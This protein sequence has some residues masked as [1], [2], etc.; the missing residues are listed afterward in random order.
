MLPVILIPTLHFLNI[1]QKRV[2]NIRFQKLKFVLDVEIVEHFVEVVLEEGISSCFIVFAT[3]FVGFRAV[4]L[5]F[6][7]LVILDEAPF[8]RQTQIPL[9]LLYLVLNIAVEQLGLRLIEIDLEFT[10]GLNFYWLFFAT[11][12]LFIKLLTIYLLILI[13]F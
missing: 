7:V 4:F 6:L 3:R 8:V 10:V 11:L 5:V 1:F 13:I 12:V 2:K 9:T